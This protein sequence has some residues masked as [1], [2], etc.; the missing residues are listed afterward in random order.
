MIPKH[1]EGKPGRI[2]ACNTGMMSVV[3]LLEETDT[4]FLV[5]AI[6]EKRPKKILKNNP[7]RKIFLGTEE[8]MAWIQKQRRK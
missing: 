2:L 6:D 3:K 4:Y 5:H 7:K 8:A 1:L